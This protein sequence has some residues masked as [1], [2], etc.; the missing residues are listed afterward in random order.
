MLI[1]SLL[2]YRNYRNRQKL[3]QAKI[4]ELETEKQLTATEAVLKGEEQERTRLAKDLHDGLGRYVKRNKIF[5]KQYE[6]E[7]NH[8]TWQCPGI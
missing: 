6:R 4:E 2:I 5:T 8:D 3:Q 7:F 1:I